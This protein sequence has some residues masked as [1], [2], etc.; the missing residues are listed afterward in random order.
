MK[1]KEVDRTA[2][3]AWSPQPQVPIYL[4]AGT[5]AQQLDASFSTN[6]NLEVY[7]LNLSESG[8]DMPMVASLPVEQRFHK[9]VWGGGAGQATMPSGLLVGGADRG[10]ISMYDAAKLVKGAEDALVLS[11]DKHTGPVA[12][13]DFNPFQGNLLASGASE[14]EIHIWDVNKLSAP[15]TPGAKSQPLEEVR[16]VAWNRQ[17]QHIMAS[18]FAS[19]CVVWDLRKNDPIIKVSDSTS[20]S[21]WK[22]VAWH[23]EVATQMALASED[24]HTPVIQIW[25]LRQAS[26]PMKQLEGHTA[27]VLSIAWCQADADLLLS[28]GKDNR[29]LV[30]NPNRGAGEIVAELPTSNQWSFEVSWCPR[31]PGVIASASFDGHVSVHSLMGGQQQVQPSSRVEESFGASMNNAANQPGPQ[32]TMQLKEPPKWLRRPCGASFGFGGRL[33]TVEQAAGVKPTLYLST[34]VTEPELV[35]DSA[36][37]ETSLQEG[38][39]PDF[40]QAKLLQMDKKSP[41]AELWEYLAAS[42]QG[43]AAA[44]QFLSLLGINHEDIKAAIN[45]VLKPEEVTKALDNL[46]VEEKKGVMED[47]DA[48]GTGDEFDLI[49]A[50]GSSNITQPEEVVKP[51]ALDSSFTLSQAPSSDGLLV[52]ALLAGDMELAVEVCVKQG[53]FAEALVLAIRGGGDLLQRTQAQYFQ[54]AAGGP[55]CLALLEA[56]TMH[57]WAKLVANC[58]LDSWRE[59]LGALL[60]YCAP[61]E[62]EQLAAQLGDRLVGDGKQSEALLCF[63][64]AGEMDKAVE[65]WLMMEG[66]DLAKASGLQSLVEVVVM[67][68][69]AVAARGLPIQARSDGQ[70]SQAL[71]KYAGLLAGQGSLRTALSYLSQVEVGEGE[72]AELK[73]RL[74]QSLAPRAQAPVQAGRQPARGRQSSLTPAPRKISNEPP[75]YNTYGQQQPFMQPQEPPVN[76]YQP[77]KPPSM[78]REPAPPVPTFPPTFPNAAPAPSAARSSNPLLGGRRTVDASVAS[79]APQYQGFQPAPTPQFSGFQPQEPP[80][81]SSPSHPGGAGGGHPPQ[82]PAGL[83]N[84]AEAAPPAAP[85]AV[86][87]RQPDQPGEG[88]APP[89][90][91]GYGWNDPPPATVAKNAFSRQT[92]AAPVQPAEPPQQFFTPAPVQ[93]QQPTP[94]WGGFQQQQP[95]HQQQFQAPPQPEPAPPANQPA[96]WGGFQPAAAQQPPQGPPANQQQQQAAAP[97]P[98]QP[99]A[100]IPAEH[101]VIQD[102][103]ES[104]RSKCQQA[105]SHPQIRRKLEDVSSKLDILYNKLRAGS[106]SAATLQGLHT[107]LQHIW[108]YDYPACM[109]VIAG[110]IAGGSFAEMSDFMPGV[111]ML[112]QVAQQQGVYVEYQQ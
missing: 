9:L 52:S 5:A 66:A 37:L 51:T 55:H 56:V 16:G 41:Q 67:V 98:A 112:L 97:E 6:S 88:W 8:H 89:V 84:P 78:E 4:A 74:E 101:Q 68:R 22:C 44:G 92:P 50:H 3:I 2:N 93:Q 48:G 104:L 57:Q 43:E 12:A 49:A 58:T 21:R 59:A 45:S 27:G 20:R 14:S 73:Q 106:L 76:T 40:C 69:A 109:Q 26:S 11:I 86:L 15:M 23:P 108:Q 94:G 111:K 102:V 38:N 99:P 95:P 46:A 64:V 1:V 28:C 71:A 96:T 63:I 105:S 18:T 33:V 34:V 17:V 39:F 70:V 42:F 31:N 47:G 72:L 32:V 60:T 19:R 90:S 103:M 75:S 65:S 62:R 7:S 53:R 54:Q 83:F 36:K 107:I 79:P 61:G 80:Q 10:V 110:L 29:I 91:S 35:A 87:E 25:D 100:P 85:P 77:Y 13:L 82:P 81:F 30:W 24:D